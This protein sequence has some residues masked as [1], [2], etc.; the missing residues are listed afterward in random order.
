MKQ[1][2]AG[3]S[4]SST[5]ETTVMTVFPSIAAWSLGRALGQLY[6]IHS[7]PTKSIT[8]GR[9]F[10]AMGAP[11]AL[12]LYFLNLAPWVCRRYRLTNRRVIVQQGLKPTDERWVGLGEFDSIQVESR[13]G[14]EWYR[15]GDLVFRKGQVETFRIYAVRN[16]DTFRATCLKAHKGFVGVN[17]ALQQ[18]AAHA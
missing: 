15:C 11:L 4:P 10:L 9:M 14:Y 12:P 6:S 2:I 18:Q 1:A 13:P 3:V 7:G 8:F 16:P 5:A 17:K